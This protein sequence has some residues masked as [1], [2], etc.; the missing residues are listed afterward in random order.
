MSQ[1]PASN[2]ANPAFVHHV[3][4][5]IYSLDILTPGKAR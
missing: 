5:E 3:N 4:Q 1:A 2:S